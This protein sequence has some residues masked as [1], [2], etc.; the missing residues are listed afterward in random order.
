MRCNSQFSP[1]AFK[2]ERVKGHEGRHATRDAIEAGTGG[3]VTLHADTA[4][5]ITW[6]DWT[7]PRAA[8]PQPAP[9]RNLDQPAVTDLVLED[10]CAR[11]A[12]GT[13]K[14]G[15]RLQPHNGRDALMDLY[16]EL[17]D[18]VC[19]TRQLIFERDGK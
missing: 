1:L 10:F 14:Y 9:E 13:K 17:L 12:F 18:A 4:A 15:T 8:Q 19:Y 3:A 5:L 16:Q 6:F 7:A 11:D 2:C